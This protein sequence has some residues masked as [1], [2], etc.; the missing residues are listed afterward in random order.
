MS[1]FN[2]VWAPRAGW[3]GAQLTSTHVSTLGRT[4][5][6]SNT[7]SLL[8]PTPGIITSYPKS[9]AL[10]VA[11]NMNALVAAVSAGQ[12]VTVQA[13]KRLNAGTPADKTLTATLSVMADVVTTTDWTYAFPI[14]ATDT[15][16]LFHTTDA[17]RLDFV[18]SG[19]VST[20]P[21]VTISAMWAIRRMQ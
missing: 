14:T 16:C 7:V 15:D 12:T 8:L 3:F 21:I 6:D 18:S 1:A 4:I 17:C 13:F 20:Q 19:A 10:L 11:L 9:E 2:R 5:G